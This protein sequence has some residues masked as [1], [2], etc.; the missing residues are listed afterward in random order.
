MFEP[1]ATSSLRGHW[2]RGDVRRQGVGGYPKNWKIGATSLMR[3]TFSNI[4]IW[5]KGVKWEIL[6]GFFFIAT[7]SRGQRRVENNVFRV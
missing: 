2:S 7:L 6:S 4:I 1:E 5:G 3:H